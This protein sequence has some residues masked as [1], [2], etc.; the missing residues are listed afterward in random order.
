AQEKSRASLIRR[1]KLVLFFMA[2]ACLYFL[3]S[4]VNTQIEIY[5]ER[6]TLNE[7]KAAINEKQLENDELSRVILGEDD[8]SYIERIARE[9]LGYAAADERVFEDAAGTE[10]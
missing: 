9:K 1:R 6:Q 10:G 8:S 7:I 3:Y 5:K 2:L 4:I